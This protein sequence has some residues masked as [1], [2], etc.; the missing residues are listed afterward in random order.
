MEDVEAQAIAIYE[1]EQ[2]A[3]AQYEEE[4]GGG[5][6]TEADQIETDEGRRNK[7]YVDTE[8]HLTAGIGHLLTQEEKKLY[9]KGAVVPEVVVDEWYTK[10]LE[11]ARIDASNFY[12]SDKGE[13]NNILQNMAF[14][15]GSSRLGGFKKLK[16]ALVEE[17][18]E[19]AADQML[20]SKWS[21]QVKGRA[22]RLANRMRALVQEDV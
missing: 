20:D 7:S 3:I 12:V 16:K 1:A 19:E 17:D 21:G 4:Q 22:T 9:P 13:V 15:L 14:N 2:Q 10:D 11:E 6:A 5:A 8:G 18:Y